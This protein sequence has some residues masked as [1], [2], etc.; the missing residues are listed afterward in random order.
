MPPSTDPMTHEQAVAI[1][2]KH[3][4][5]EQVAP[6]LVAQAILVI[7]QGAGPRTPGEKRLKVFA[8]RR[9]VATEDVLALLDQN[10]ITGRQL[11]GALRVGTQT[12]KEAIAALI[13]SGKPIQ[14]LRG[15]GYRLVDP[16]VRTEVEQATQSAWAA[17]K[18]GA[19]WR[20]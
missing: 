16:P 9:E 2:L 12:I 4:Q 18:K 8:E 20:S 10:W 15:K 14:A 7:Q 11:A 5:C 13:R 19:S 17:Q 1:R 6:E 3:L